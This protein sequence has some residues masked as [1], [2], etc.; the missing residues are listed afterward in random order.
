MYFVWH[1]LIKRMLIREPSER[2][3]L[4]DI[5]V[6]PWVAGAGQSTNG[7]APLISTEM[8]NESDR[9]FIIKKMIEGKIAT[10]EEIAK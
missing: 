3:T 10:K 4:D 5:L 8:L 2:I 1:S 7:L 6:H 9:S